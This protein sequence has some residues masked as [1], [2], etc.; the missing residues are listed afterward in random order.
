MP[1]QT[2]TQ[3]QMRLF[4]NEVYVISEDK[5]SNATIDGKYIVYT[6]DTCVLDVPK[7]ERSK[8]VKPVDVERLA[9]E[10]SEANISD[11][12]I[13][14]GIDCFIAG[15]A[16]KKE[17]TREDLEFAIQLAFTNGRYA[18]VSQE[19][20]ET[21]IWQKLQPLSLPSSLTI[22]DNIITEVKWND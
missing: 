8:F 21:V 19:E 11:A 12:C 20:I 16:N 14:A 22:E 3:E 18:K 1:K 13:L 15:Y 2:F 6:T 5:F 4:G 10:Y 9:T 17:F 7:L